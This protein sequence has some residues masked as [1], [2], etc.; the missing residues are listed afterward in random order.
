[1][2]IDHYLLEDGSQGLRTKRTSFVQ[3]LEA[4]GFAAWTRLEKLDE[5]AEVLRARLGPER[6]AR[7]TV[8]AA[9]RIGRR[10]D[11]GASAFA[12]NRP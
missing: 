11:G 1:M 4:N 8:S 2:V 10:L 7:R 12:G 6:V 5:V 3:L 9:G